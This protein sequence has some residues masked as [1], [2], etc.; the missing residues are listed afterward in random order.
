MKNIPFTI[1]V[2]LCAIPG[3]WFSFKNTLHE[4]FKNKLVEKGYIGG[5]PTINKISKLDKILARIIIKMDI[6]EGT[7]YIDLFCDT[8][9]YS[10]K[11][12]NET[13]KYGLKII[14]WFFMA[15]TFLILA[16]IFK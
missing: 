16:Y 3:V 5:T 11:Y 4:E 10:I 6:M 12:R 7:N 8:S 14:I 13:K 9:V 2:L 1:F 15:F